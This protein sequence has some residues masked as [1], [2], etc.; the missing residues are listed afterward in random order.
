MQGA[1]HRATGAKSAS[2]TFPLSIAAPSGIVTD[3]LEMMI[4][5]VPTAQSISIT[6]AAGGAWSLIDPGS[7]GYTE[8]VAG[9]FKLY[10]WWRVRASGDSGNPTLTGSG[11]GAICA[12]RVAYKR[13][14]FDPADPFEAET[15]STETTADVSMSHTA[16]TSSGYGNTVLCVGTINRDSNTASVPVMANSSLESLASRAD[17]CTAAS[18]GGGFGLTEGKQSAPGAAGTFTVDYLGTGS[19]KAMA[20]VVL[21]RYQPTAVTAGPL[22]VGE[23]DNFDRADNADLN[24]NGGDW[25][26]NTFNQAGRVWGRRYSMATAGPGTQHRSTPGGGV[27]GTYREYGGRV[28]AWL[29]LVSGV[30]VSNEG[31]QMTLADNGAGDDLFF[32]LTPGG[33]ALLQMGGVT[34]A[35]VANPSMNPG[36]AFAVVRDGTTVQG[37]HK[38]YG[39]A[40]SKI[41]EKT[42]AGFT[43]GTV[44]IG[45]STSGFIVAPDLEWDNFG[46]GTLLELHSGSAVLSGAAHITA[47]GS[48]G[49]AGAGSPISTA[50]HLTAGGQKGGL[51][52]AVISTAAHITA[53]I[54]VAARGAA[55][56]LSGGGTGSSAATVAKVGPVHLSGGG[57]IQA[58]GAGLGNAGRALFA[59]VGRFARGRAGRANRGRLPR[60]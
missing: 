11:A 31:L 17:Y 15:T 36:D 37:W 30:P 6:D 18:T 12:C 51:G 40:W 29:Q 56:R 46:G 34:L 2:A 16:G 42:S 26:E 13:G 25:I 24:A 60:R 47:A 44:A 45:F 32:T 1:S 41:L 55:V 21:K 9:G 4:A 33:N 20:S 59:R 8:T 39:S 52:A 35:S 57:A 58:F 48:K 38:P 54:G 28:E 50:A 49:A 27:G 7:L 22:G 43:T 10:W 14:T 19:A 23:L 3:D 5:T 53:G